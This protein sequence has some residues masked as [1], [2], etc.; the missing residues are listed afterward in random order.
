ML[1]L[2]LCTPEA[3]NTLTQ[4]LLGVR[5]DSGACVVLLE[6]YKVIDV[7]RKAE[8]N[9]NDIQNEFQRHHP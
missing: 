2:L 6:V 9:H 4:V 5:S 1:D 3:K 7:D 8:Q